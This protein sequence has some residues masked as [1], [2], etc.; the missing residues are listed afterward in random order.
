MMASLRL[1]K[2]FSFT[3]FAPPELIGGNWAKDKIT[4]PLLQSG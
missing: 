2:T 4:S 1:F 3:V